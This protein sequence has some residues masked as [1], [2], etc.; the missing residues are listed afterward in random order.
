MI[1]EKGQLQSDAASRFESCAQHHA[2]R[3]FYHALCM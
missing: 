2:L 1:A 3:M